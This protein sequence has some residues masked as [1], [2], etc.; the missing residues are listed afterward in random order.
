MNLAESAFDG[1]AD[2]LHDDERNQAYRDAIG[3]AAAEFSEPSAYHLHAIDIGTAAAFSLFISA[4]EGVARS[5]LEVNPK[6]ARLAERVVDDNNYAD[7]VSVVNCHSTE[8]HNM[9]PKASLMTHELLDSGLHSE[10]LLPAIRH[11]WKELL[12][13]DAVT[14]PHSVMLFAQ[15]V[16]SEFLRAAANLLPSAPIVAPPNMASCDGAA[17]YLELHAAPLLSECVP[18]AAPARVVDFDLTRAPPEG[19]QHPPPTLLNKSAGGSS[20]SSSDD[21]RV[22]DAILTWWQCILHP[23]SA[24]QPPITLYKPVSRTAA[25]GT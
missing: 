3:R 18:L 8:V 16:R 7:T 21:S 12:T 14:V 1:H 4:R 9:E 2:M 17:G 24:D 22:P 25:R 10:G 13:P 11:A 23:G 15:P 5:P 19:E 20:S 6:L